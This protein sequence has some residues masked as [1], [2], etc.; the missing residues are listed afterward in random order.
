MTVP[1]A[2]VVKIQKMAEALIGYDVGVT[3]PL[4]EQGFDIHDICCLELDIESEFDL[5]D[6]MYIGDD[7]TIE[8][9]ASYINNLAS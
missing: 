3:L 8:K 2:L 5:E 7:C 1:N 6:D 9:I 4:Y